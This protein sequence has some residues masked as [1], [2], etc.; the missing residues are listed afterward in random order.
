MPK[1]YTLQTETVITDSQGT[2][3]PAYLAQP[4]ATGPWPIVVVL[5]EVFGVNTHIRSVAERI[6]KDGYIAIA[7]HLYHRQ[8]AN[9]DVGYGEAE[10]ALGRKYKV[11]TNAQELL[12]DVR[13]AI[14]FARTECGSL[15]SGVGCIGFCFGGHVAYLVATLPE[16]RATASFYG[17]G[18]VNSTPGG[19]MP[20]LSK[21]TDISG[22]LY[23]FFGKQD[24]LISQQ[25]VTQIKAELSKHNVSHQV[26]EYEDAGHGFCCDQRDS[27]MPEAATHAWQQV[28]RLF[29]K[30]L[31]P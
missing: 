29:Q 11:G 16:V 9:F 14:S 28:D 30:S 15:D 19:R 24:P 18:M 27:Y 12:N 13:G 7:P 17:A 5:Q 8:I 20:T 3:I 6:A 21:T 10:L 22:E 1:T 26:F 2:G 4:G 31:K 23:A 25:E